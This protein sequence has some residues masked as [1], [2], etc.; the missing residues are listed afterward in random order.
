MPNTAPIVAFVAITNTERARRF[1]ADVL[2]LTLLR[3]EPYALVFDANGTLLRLAKVAAVTP[4]PYTVLGWIVADIR[5]ERGRLAALG[6]AFERYEGMPQDELGICA[7][8]DGAR[9][10]WFKDPD[11]NVLSLTQ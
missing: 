11:G 2:G 6:V 3:D 7:F 9:V 5:A 4:A 10:L 1:Y 8:P